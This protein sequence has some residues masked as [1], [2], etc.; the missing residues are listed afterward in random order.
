[1]I[2]PLTQQRWTE[3]LSEQEIVSVAASCRRRSFEAGRVIFQRGDVGREMYVVVSGR[4]RISVLSSEGRELAL[5]YAGPSSLIGEI[6][7]LTDRPRTADATAMTDVEMLSI[8]RRDF[9]RIIEARPTVARA[10]IKILCDRIS[11]ATEQLQSIALYGIEARLARLLLGFA[12]MSR[13]QIGATVLIDPA[14]TQSEIADLIG[15]T[16][17]KVNQA[18]GALE[19]SG[20]ICRDAKR[21]RCCLLRLEAIADCER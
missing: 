13:M 9:D 7:V 1:M 3:L 15:A 18:L 2:D 8:T 4:V 20:A 21:I 10:L 6:A 14:L 19:E 17:P 16:R 11:A 5:H 12:R